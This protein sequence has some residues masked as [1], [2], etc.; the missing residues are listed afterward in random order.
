LTRKQTNLF[1][2]SCNE[3]PA[4]G[5]G[6]RDDSNQDKRSALIVTAFDQMR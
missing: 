6:R 2:K 4:C 1:G 3:L 5:L